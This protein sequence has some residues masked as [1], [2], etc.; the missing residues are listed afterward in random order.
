M[1]S[2]FDPTAEAEVK[3][4]SDLIAMVRKIIVED[5]IYAIVNEEPKAEE[6]K[7][8]IKEYEQRHKAEIDKRQSKRDDEKRN[9]QDRIDAEHRQ[10]ENNRK[11]VMEEEKNIA[12]NK[13]KFKAETTEV[14]LGEPNVSAHHVIVEHGFGELLQC[15]YFY[16]LLWK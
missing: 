14:L 1:D 12:I 3:S 5:M 11:L 2:H 15:V 16:P 7:A 10:T 4:D 8:S 6:I 9:I 13:R